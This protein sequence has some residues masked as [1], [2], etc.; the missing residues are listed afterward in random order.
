MAQ[1]PK[2]CTESSAERELGPV[3]C[4]AYRVRPR[5][6]HLTGRA[7]LA[8][9]HSRS[10]PRL[11]CRARPGPASEPVGQVSAPAPSLHSAHC[12]PR[13]RC[14]TAT[15]VLSAESGRAREGGDTVKCLLCLLQ[16]WCA[17]QR[18][19]CMPLFRRFLQAGCPCSA[20]CSP[21]VRTGRTW[22]RRRACA[23]G[24][25]TE[26]ELVSRYFCPCVTVW[27]L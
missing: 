3:L 7:A 8:R 10:S 19:E 4:K 9:S 20:K 17:A 21:C 25:R 16:T 6:A 24:F 14:A 22:E 2:N 23:K 1:E 18:E 11:G 12:C 15:R 5:G 26:F 27:W 13:A